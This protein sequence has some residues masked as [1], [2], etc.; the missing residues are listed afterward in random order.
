MSHLMRLWHFLSSVNSFFKRA[1]TATSEARCLI[2]GQTLRLLPYFMC[3]NSKGSGKTV[4][5]RRLT[6]AFAGR[7]C[8]KYHNL[9]RWLK[10]TDPINDDVN[11]T[12]HKHTRLI[13]YYSRL[14]LWNI[15]TGTLRFS[16][17][18]PQSVLFTIWT[19]LVQLHSQIWWA[20][21]RI[22]L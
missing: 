8:D 10:R 4:R 7:P 6:W 5:M 18:F 16:H 13:M 3:E 20:T 19:V 1:W 21:I 12:R 2:F 11:L 17:C 14:V 22:I 9:M 15:I